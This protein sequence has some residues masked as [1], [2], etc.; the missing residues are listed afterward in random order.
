MD[1][2]RS[3]S[4]RI[5]ANVL[6]AI[7]QLNLRICSHFHSIN[8][9]IRVVFNSYRNKPYLINGIVFNEQE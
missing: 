5:D 2:E 3:N 8:E 7:L 6:T 1:K 4:I 9:V